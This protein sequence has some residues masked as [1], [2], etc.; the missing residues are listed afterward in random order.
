MLVSTHL[1]MQRSCSATSCLNQAFFPS[2]ENIVY[3]PLFLHY[4]RVAQHSLAWRIYK[5]LSST[6]LGCKSTSVIRLIILFA[7]FR[8]NIVALQHWH[9]KRFTVSIIEFSLV[10]SEVK[11]STHRCAVISTGPYSRLNAAAV[12]PAQ[13]SRRSSII[14]LWKWLRWLI[15]WG[16][17]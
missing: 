3:R 15:A 12:P 7:R 17:W 6:A 10:Q 9:R 16:T 11:L 8:S 2:T 5:M 4:H 13:V 14:V 1:S